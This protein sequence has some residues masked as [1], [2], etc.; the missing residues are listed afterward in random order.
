M[1]SVALKLNTIQPTGT[2][3]TVKLMENDTS[4]TVRQNKASPPQPQVTEPLTRPQL[5]TAR[6]PS[7]KPTKNSKSSKNKT[8]NKSKE[9]KR[10]K[11]NKTQRPPEK[12]KKIIPTTPTHFPYFMDNYC[13]PECACYGR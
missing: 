9:N 3:N 12:R 6:T 4:L 10:R 8:V 5:T 7:T 11:D 2:P 1:I 13:P